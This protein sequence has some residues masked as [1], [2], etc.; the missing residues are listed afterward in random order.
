MPNH[1]ETDMYIRGS[2]EDIK[3]FGKWLEEIEPLNRD[4]CRALIPY[5]EN[6]EQ[7]DRELKAIY[8]LGG[9][10]RKSAEARRLI[11]DELIMEQP[12]L[13]RHE[14]CPTDIGALMASDQVVMPDGSAMDEAA[15][16]AAEA[17]KPNPFAALAALKK[18]KGDKG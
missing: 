10:E 17:A 12:I 14:Q 6:F 16:Q 18:E 9:D 2:D 8:K 11:E 7:M 4:I 1:C 15:V 5:P 13:P 3:V